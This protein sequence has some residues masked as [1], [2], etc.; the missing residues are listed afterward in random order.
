MTEV[1]PV[2]ASDP[3]TVPASDPSTDD[4]R[5]RGLAALE[6]HEWPEAFRLLSQADAAGTLSA[7]DLE[8]LAQSA[9]FT[10]Q[11]DHEIEILERAFAAHQAES[12]PHRAAFI[13]VSVAEKYFFMGNFVI[14]G[15]WIRRA[16][17]LIGAEGDTYVHGYIAMA[18]SWVAR[19][20]GD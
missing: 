13:A 11:P 20:S 18:R 6:R 5:S 4:D 15:S 3:S 14:S 10:A 12:D 17:K 8:G 19:G 7:Q 9:F 1:A 16:E 2:P